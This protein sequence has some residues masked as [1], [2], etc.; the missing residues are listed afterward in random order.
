MT[1]ETMK[2]QGAV[3]DDARALLAR[4][5]GGDTEGPVARAVAGPAAGGGLPFDSPMAEAIIIVD[6]AQRPALIVRNNTFEQPTLPTW[7]TLLNANRIRLERALRSVGR[8]E[9]EGHPTFPWAGTAWML[10]D[11]GIAIT[12]RHVG[13][14]F[15]RKQGSSFKFLNGV[16][17]KPIKAKVDFRE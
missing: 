10:G 5:T 2:I 4:M 15:A 17:G 13:E 7:K 14:I 11:K 1:T 16:N 9:L 3:N 8:L 6:R 12:N